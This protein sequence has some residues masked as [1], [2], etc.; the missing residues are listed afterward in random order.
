M[1]HIA[2]SARLPSA[3]ACLAALLLG[4]ITPAQT[5]NIE[6]PRVLDERLTIELLAAEP[7]LVTPVGLAADEAGRIFVIESHTHF[8]P[9]DY[10]GPPADRIRVFTDADLDGRVERVATWFEGT[11][12][13]MGIGLHPD[14]S[15]YL[16]TRS[17]VWRLRDVQGAGA[18]DQAERLVHLET[19][20]NYPHNG[21]AGFAFDAQGWVYFGMGENLGEPYALIG[22]DGI[23]HVG[24]GEGGNVFRT[25][26]DGSRLE[27]VATGFW[28]PFHL[29]FDGLGHLF[30]V[31]NDP[32]ARPPCRLLHIVSGG[33][34]GYRYRNG[35]RGLHPFTAWNGELPGTLPM[36]AGTGEAPSGVAYY[37]H[38]LL[39]QE[40]QGALLVTSWGDHR[41]DRFR[42]KRQGASF[43]SQAEPFVVGG[44]NFR[45]VG[46][47]VLPDGSLVVSD[48]VDK[49]YDLHGKGRLWRVRLRDASPVS[50]PAR[51]G[52]W[53]GSPAERRWLAMRKLSAAAHDPQQIAV[54]WQSLP[55]AQS[56][57]Y[58]LEAALAGE[59]GEAACAAVYECAACDRCA[60][61]REAVAERVPQRFI[62]APWFPAEDEHPAVRAA[63]L[64]RLVG[65]AHLERLVAACRD[66]DPFVRRAAIAG[67]VQSASPGRLA[68]L[69]C[70]D[71]PELR[72][73]A[74]V[75]LRE[76]GSHAASTAAR[77]LADADLRV[78]Q[79]AVQWVAE[80]RLDACR[81]QLAA[82]LAAEGIP[83]QLFEACLAALE[84]LDSVQ[85]KLPHEERGG[86]EYVAALLARPDLPPATLAR[87]L[88]RLRPDHPVLAPEL[89]DRWLAIPQPE[90]QLEVVRT[91]RD[92]SGDHV[93]KRLAALAQDEHADI[94]LRAEAVAGL[95]PSNPP[96]RRLLLELARHRSPTLRSE[97]L[98][99]LQLAN[100]TAE[101]RRWL[102]GVAATPAEQELLGR[103][104]HPGQQPPRPPKNDLAAWLTL[105]EG[106][107]DPAAGERIFFHPQGP[108]CYRCHELDGRG[109]AAGP[110]LSLVRTLPRARLLE[111]LLAPSKEVAPH[112]VPWQL[113]MHDGRV[114]LGLLV[115]DLV[116]GEQVYMAPSGET[117]VVHPLDIES[118]TPHAGSIMPD[119]LVEQLTLQELRDLIARLQQ[120]GSPQ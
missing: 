43:S 27:R 81:P 94:S 54:L 8:R 15:V 32:D 103:L 84:R 42:L 110:E 88:R 48:W 2:S 20:G 59:L 82:L 23:T 60:D 77:L 5:A 40:Y 62:E 100:L 33:D 17:D 3:I 118:R 10:A 19:A 41:L 87:G 95:A 104:L 11:V 58:L 105:L 61:L 4:P 108:R 67:L 47:A 16:A 44:E 92:Q 119:N 70:A 73:A 31:D 65:E 30:A 51:T 69:A 76:Q 13:S 12:A 49:S 24:G 116:S 25:R 18:A 6:Y 26:T 90:L 71:D 36:T 98:R 37:A 72:L 120:G 89:L 53:P 112:F 74:A 99:T 34:Y 56:R 83:R 39:P 106:E 109:G 64:R 117:F 45:P 78:R 57:M 86:D 101:E 97:A 102:D 68:A 21:L 9:S 91:L 29:A 75:A 111:S 113:V 1:S 14:G 114:L 115:R 63:V 28:N 52:H 22:S 107:A 35:R 66:A 96:S 93:Q 79:A 46:I 7:D 38:R 80:C 55:E 50:A 85:K